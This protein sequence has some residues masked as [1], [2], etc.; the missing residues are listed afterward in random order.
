MAGNENVVSA[1]IVSFV[2]HILRPSHFHAFFRVF[3]NNAGSSCNINMQIGNAI[4]RKNCMKLCSD[5]MI[6]LN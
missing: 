6:V 1:D 3:V 4:F 2:L 5:G